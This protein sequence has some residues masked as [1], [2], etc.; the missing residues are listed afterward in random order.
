MATIAL[1]LLLGAGAANAQTVI[2]EEGTLRALAIDD[3]NVDGTLYDV[4]FDMQEFAVEVYGDFP[5]TEYTFTAPETAQAARDA[6][7]AALNDAGAI[8]VGPIE[9]EGVGGVYNIGYGAGRLFE[10]E[11]VVVARAAIEGTDWLPLNDNP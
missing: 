5:G 1:S 2:F 9:F 11:Y 10:V 4:I 7:S 6:I 3:L 8:G